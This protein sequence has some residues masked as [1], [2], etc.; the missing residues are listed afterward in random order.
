MIYLLRFYT[1][2]GCTWAPL[3]ALCTRSVITPL[4]VC[5]ARKHQ[6]GIEAAER[7]TCH[8]GVAEVKHHRSLI[9][10]NLGWFHQ[11]AKMARMQLNATQRTLYTSF[12]W[13][14]MSEAFHHPAS[15]IFF[16]FTLWFTRGLQSEVVDLIE[17]CPY[18]HPSTMSWWRSFILN[19]GG[20]SG[21]VVHLIPALHTHID[22]ECHLMPY[23]LNQHGPE[24]S[25]R[26]IP[27]N[28]G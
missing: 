4:H 26:F 6:K 16:L 28:K 14:M 15:R 22:E 20:Q 10:F 21:E 8:Y 24:T 7:V 13:I 25:E 23:L 1:S 5:T 12:C 18:I 11:A 27:N 3:A 19:L 17:T 9:Q 2:D